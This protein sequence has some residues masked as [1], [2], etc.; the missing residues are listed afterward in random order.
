ME[1]LIRAIFGL[2]FLLAILLRILF[3]GGEVLF[4]S[5]LKY[6]PV[7]IVACVTWYF[8]A[9]DGPLRF[10]E[11]TKVAVAEPL[12]LRDQVL[13]IPCPHLIKRAI[14]KGKKIEVHLCY[15]KEGEEYSLYLNDELAEVQLQLPDGRWIVTYSNQDVKDRFA[16]REAPQRTTV[17]ERMYRQDI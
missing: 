5:L 12:T 4:K 2:L 10:W 11:S 13:N 1:A 16:S 9:P 3:F 8:F 6:W 7:P 14:T 15:K 17:Y